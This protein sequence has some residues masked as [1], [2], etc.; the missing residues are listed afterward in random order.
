MLE[1]MVEVGRPGVC[2]CICENLVQWKLPGL[3]EGDPMESQV[4]FR[5]GELG[6]IQLSFWP[7]IPHGNFQITQAITR[8]QAVL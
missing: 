5:V 6:Y 2:V 4:R 3:H 7:N 8:Q 1:E